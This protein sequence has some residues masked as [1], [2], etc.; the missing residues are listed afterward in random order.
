ML[1]IDIRAPNINYE[2]MLRIQI[3]ASDAPNKKKKIFEI[4]YQY[5]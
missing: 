5:S 2:K 1:R 4:Y 3:A